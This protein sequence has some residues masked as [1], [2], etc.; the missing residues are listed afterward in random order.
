MQYKSLD[1]VVNVTQSRAVLAKF[2]I[3]EDDRRYYYQLTTWDGEFIGDLVGPFRSFV[4][5]VTNA[6]R[7]QK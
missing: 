3:G 1:L 6:K 4:V 7:G 2:C 5:A